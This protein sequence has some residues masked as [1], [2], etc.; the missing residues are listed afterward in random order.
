MAF[1]SLFKI[2]RL[3]SKHHVELLWVIMASLADPK[4]P[5]FNT[6]WRAFR[7]IRGGSLEEVQ[8]AAALVEK[9]RDILHEYL[10]ELR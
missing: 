9:L 2:Q 8:V 6:F 10:K 7:D 1:G 5:A 4:H 3:L